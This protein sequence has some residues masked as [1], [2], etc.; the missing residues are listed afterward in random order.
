M[1]CG[2]ARSS[3]SPSGPIIVRSDISSPKAQR[4]PC[5]SAI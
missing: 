3:G 1:A 2:C 5:S 4:G